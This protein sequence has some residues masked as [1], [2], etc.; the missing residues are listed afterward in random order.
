MDA[1]ENAAFV[2]GYS[3]GYDILRKHVAE[4][5][6]LRATLEAEKDSAICWHQEEI[7]KRDKTIAE[8]LGRTTVMTEQI[9]T[10]Q[11]GEIKP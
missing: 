11:T 6:E 5:A 7:R 10:F 8:L 3:A 1:K 4:I 9:I 2:E